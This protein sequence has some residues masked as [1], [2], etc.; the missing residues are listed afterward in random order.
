MN[1]T[2]KTVIAAAWITFVVSQVFIS[3]G[4]SLDAWL[5]AWNAHRIYES[6]GYLPSRA[7]GFPLHEL[8]VTP[9]IL[10]GGWILSNLASTVAG[11][12][13]LAG[14]FVLANEKEF[15]HPVLV[16]VT[17][18][19]M[20]IIVDQ[21]S[22]TIDFMFSLA[23]CLWSWILLLR[24]RWYLAAVLIGIACGFR[25][26][27]CFMI[28]PAIVYTWYVKRDVKLSLL[29]LLTG[30]FT[31]V[32]AFSPALLTVGFKD[33]AAPLAGKL[34]AS[35]RMLIGGYRFLRT[36]GI[37]QWAFVAGAMV[38]GLRAAWKSDRPWR[39]SHTVYHGANVLMWLMIFPIFPFKSEYFLLA[40]PSL[41][42]LLD[43]LLDR[44]VMTALA[45]VILSYHVVQ[46][47]LLAGESGERRVAPS[48][49]TG[50][51]VRSIQARRFMRSTREIATAHRVE[52]PTLLMFGSAW[53][54]AANPAWV[55]DTSWN[56]WRQKDGNLFLSECILEKE[57]LEHLH[58]RGLAIYV[59]RG[60]KT[61]YSNVLDRSVWGKYVEVVDSLEVFYDRKI[62]GRPLQ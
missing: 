36:L 9:L 34:P 29:M 14:L 51:T 6:G 26:T 44:K 39:S 11:I 25:I 22:C 47:D 1:T 8:L 13:F 2:Q 60:A 55:F 10:S 24:K 16:V 31:G 4:S 21:A 40:V 23:L 3:Y 20:P 28:G 38:W 52:R 7:T 61:E 32:I 46:F 56:L 58:S 19:F 42:F 45:V 18:A 50:Y 43:R 17:L 49:A 5:L 12:A 53:T 48:I 33:Y 35:Y 41:I 30:A 37:L 15:R 59:W 54:T 57:R 27:S 62:T